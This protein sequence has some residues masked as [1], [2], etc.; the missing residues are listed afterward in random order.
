MKR[1]NIFALLLILVLTLTGCGGNTQDDV[2][3]TTL[4]YA[5]YL[6]DDN[7]VVTIKVNGVGEMKL[8][9][10][11]DV[12]KN[13]VNNFI[14][15]IQDK[16]YSGSTF[17]RIIEDFM[18]QGGIVSETNCSIKGEFSSNGVSNNLSHSRGV[19]SMARTTIKNSA[20]SQFFIVHEDSS[21]LDGNY[22]AFGGLISGFSIL[23]E[24]AVVATNSSDTPVSEIVIQ[25]ITVD[26][27][28]YTIDDVVCS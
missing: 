23:D 8:Q 15:Y 12:A 10:F 1:L 7:P 22:A 5:S 11:P 28:G 26:L 16:D 25:S 9:L 24:L 27:N 17:H 13:T 19:I 6:S 2:D 4:P 20:T 18:I 14:V 3:L 21:F